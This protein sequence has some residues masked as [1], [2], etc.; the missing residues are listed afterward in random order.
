MRVLAAFIVLV[1]AASLGQASHLASASVTGPLVATDGEISDGGVTTITVP[2]A[3]GADPLEATQ[4]LLTGVSAPMSANLT[5]TLVVQSCQPSCAVDLGKAG[6]FVSVETDNVTE[7]TLGL[8]LFC[9]VDWTAR[10]T[11]EPGEADQRTIDI[12][13]IANAGGGPGSGDDEHNA[14]LLGVSQVVVTAQ[15]NILPCGGGT[16][17]LT[18]EVLDAFGN[19]IPGVEFR[20]FTTA[21]TLVQTSPDT[22]KLTLGPNQYLA[23]VTATIPDAID[24]EIDEAVTTVGLECTGNND[25]T[26]VVTANP[27]VITCTGTTTLTAAVRDINGHVVTGRGY[28]FV[29]SAGLLVVDPNDASNEVAVARL[30]LRPG[31]GDATVVVSS[32]LLY[33]TYEEIDDVENDFVVDETAMVTVQQNCLGTTTGQI[34]VN[35][36]VVNLA[37][38]ERAFIGLSVMD[39]D[40]QTVVDGTPITLIATGG[41]NGGF[42]YAR[43]QDSNGA[44]SISEQVLPQVEVPTSHGEANAIYVA[45]TDYNGEVKVT[46]ASGDTYG[47][48]KLTVSGCGTTAAAAPV[49]VPCTPI[50]DG[51]CISPPN[52]G[53]NRI[54]PPS[55]GSAGLR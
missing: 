25:Q 23:T 1:T 49:T 44:R 54:T 15:P 17:V 5:G 8:R 40:I 46:A 2:L 33:G 37:C 19:H 36:S 53:A 43:E 35:S 14:V 30:S 21:G 20:F 10:V 26:L 55:T 47:F 48:R 13:C 50:G 16:T 42:L 11:A 22:A 52:T 9:N 24:Q 39:E 41:G 29:T 31:D 38:G 18:A 7:I 12:D 4:I 27:N 45:P 3:G 28:H 34:K 6:T 51:I 32:G